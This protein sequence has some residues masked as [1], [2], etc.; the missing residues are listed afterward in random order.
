MKITKEHKKIFKKA[1]ER[2][3]TNEFESWLCPA[4]GLAGSELNAPSHLIE[5]CK[6]ILHYYFN[7]HGGKDYSSVIWLYDAHNDNVTLLRELR[8][9]ALNFLINFP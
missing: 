9:L 2:Y 6:D 1:L 8:T 7:D 5:E 3:V 4:I